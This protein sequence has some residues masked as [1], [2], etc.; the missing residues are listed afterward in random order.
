MFQSIKLERVRRDGCGD[1]LEGSA[2]CF[3]LVNVH[4]CMGG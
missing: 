1:G 4:M 2:I 3:A